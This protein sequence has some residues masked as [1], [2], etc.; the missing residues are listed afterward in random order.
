MKWNPAALDGPSFELNIV[1]FGG[2]VKL[3][4]VPG[5]VDLDGEYF[6]ETT[7]I[8]HRTYSELPVLWHHG[9]DATM[10]PKSL[11]KATGLHREADGWWTTVT[12]NRND[13]RVDLVRALAR[14]VPIFGS[15]QPIRSTV[16]RDGPRITH[17]QIAEATLSTSPQNTHAVIR[18]SQP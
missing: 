10:G 12:W 17:W 2:P 16:Q 8:G 5:G 11:A 13:P 7:D 1:P 6:D 4:S 14:K 3:S 18:R 15:S 9:R